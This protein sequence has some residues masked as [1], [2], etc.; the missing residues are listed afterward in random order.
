MLKKGLRG[1]FRSI[2]LARVFEWQTY[3]L[4]YAW[5][6]SFLEGENESFAAIWGGMHLFFA[7]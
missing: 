2:I 6:V 7:N 5:A 1:C 4:G 3:I